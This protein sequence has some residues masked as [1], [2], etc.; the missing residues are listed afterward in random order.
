MSG[1][2]AP[3]TLC[4]QCHCAKERGRQAAAEQ[5]S[6]GHADCPGHLVQVSPASR[7]VSLALLCCLWE[8]VLGLSS[9]LQKS[10]VYSL[11]W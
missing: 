5:Q 7:R 10:L 1:E 9:D 6:P 11:A 8:W 4:T 2:G 3:L